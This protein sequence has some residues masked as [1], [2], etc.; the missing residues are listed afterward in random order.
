[1]LSYSL[2]LKFR[3]YFQIGGVFLMEPLQVHFNPIQVDLFG[4]CPKHE[5]VKI[6]PPLFFKTDHRHWRDLKHSN[7]SRILLTLASFFRKTILKNYFF[8]KLCDWEMTI[9]QYFSRFLM[10][11]TNNDCFKNYLSFDSFDTVILW[12]AKQ[13]SGLVTTW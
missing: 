8:K 4:E 7:I 1:M 6:I 12:F 11:P 10:N 3:L 5:K 9:S 2:L 13:I